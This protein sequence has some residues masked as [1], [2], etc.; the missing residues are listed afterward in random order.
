MNILRSILA[1]VA[2]YIVMKAIV[3]GATYALPMIKPEWFLIGTPETSGYFAVN[4]GYNLFAA[5]TGGYVAA[6]LASRSPL[7]HAYALAALSVVMSIVT[8]LASEQEQRRWYRVFQVIVVPA[9]IIVGGR[10]RG[11]GQSPEPQPA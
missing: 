3:I 2:G 4:I 9:A 5:L 11:R 10:L 8:A 1:V 7:N 6:R